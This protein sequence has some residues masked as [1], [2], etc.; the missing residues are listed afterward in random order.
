MMGTLRRLLSLQQRIGI[1]LCFIAIIALLSRQSNGE[2]TITPP[3]PSGPPQLTD[4]F[5]DP[6]A[7]VWFAGQPEAIG[8]ISA[9]NSSLWSYAMSN[10]TLSKLTGEGYLNGL[11]VNSTSWNTLDGSYNMLNGICRVTVFSTV[12]IPEFASWVPYSSYNGIQSVTQITG[13]EATTYVW[14]LATVNYTL[15]VYVDTNT[16][17][18]IRYELIPTEVNFTTIWDFSPSIQFNV[19][20]DSSVFDV[21]SDCLSNYT[22]PVGNTDYLE[23]YNFHSVNDFWLNN[24]NTADIAGDAYF[25]CTSGFAVPYFQWVSQWQVQVNTTWGQYQLC[26]YG[27]CLGG[28]SNLVGRE[29]SDGLAVPNAGQCSQ[30]SNGAGYWYS[31]NS[32]SECENDAA[33]GDKNCTWKVISRM[34][35]INASCLFDN[36]FYEACKADGDA[37]FNKASQIFGLAFLSDDPEE[38]GCPPIAVDAIN[39]N[40]RAVTTK[41]AQL[42]AF[43]SSFFSFLSE[44]YEPLY[45]EM[46]ALRR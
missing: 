23:V 43:S 33:I 4:T 36:G 26:N 40:G 20:I 2:F 12:G 25:I 7:V 10:I 41:S 14:S 30:T 39:P 5:V 44:V 15:S 19:D 34:K 6:S 22:C 3:P 1:S 8:T 21:P 42:P 16:S 28:D 29:V 37:P 27:V 31:F 32:A 46:K 18:L 9:I 11:V 45:E 38:L 17:M 13:R 35:T 24:T